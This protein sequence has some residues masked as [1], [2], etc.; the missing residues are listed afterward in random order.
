MFALAPQ[1]GRRL[2]SRCYWGQRNGPSSTLGLT[3]A[4]VARMPIALLHNKYCTDALGDDAPYTI[5]EFSLSGSLGFL[6]PVG[7]GANRAHRPGPGRR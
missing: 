7:S 4:V 2:W 1:Q 5:N 6:N 3:A